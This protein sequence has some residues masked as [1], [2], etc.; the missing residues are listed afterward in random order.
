MEAVGTLIADLDVTDILGNQK[1]LNAFAPVLAQATCVKEGRGM[2]RSSRVP[3][4]TAAAGKVAGQQAAVYARH[5][6]QPAAQAEPAAKVKSGTN[7]QPAGA[8]GGKATATEAT[9]AVATVTDEPSPNSS[10]PSRQRSKAQPYWMGGTADSSPSSKQLDQQSTVP[11][12]SDA[13]L[14]SDGHDSSPAEQSLGDIGKAGAGDRKAAMAK[15]Q[16][17]SS[18]HKDQQQPTKKSRAASQQQQQQLLP[19]VNAAADAEGEDDAGQARVTQQPSKAREGHVSR[20]SQKAAGE[21][22]QASSRDGV[23]CTG[24]EEAEVVR[25][26]ATANEHHESMQGTV[27]HIHLTRVLW[28]TCHK[29]VVA[30]R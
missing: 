1:Q 15:R 17:R 25:Q 21:S 26:G 13:V 8:F 11:A 4:E 27:S 22:S 18:P 20:Q 19:E 6:K 29:P 12:A 5:C 28:T 9:E 24:G 2:A 14:A 23:N 3:R 10:R 30:R 16:T 7:K